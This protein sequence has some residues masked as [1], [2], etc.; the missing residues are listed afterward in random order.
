L[1]R[2]ELKPGEPIDK[3]L[4]R[5]KK[6]CDREG[7]TR[8]MRKNSYYEKPSERQKRREREREKE[9]SKSVRLAQ[10]KKLKARKARAKAMKAGRSPARREGGGHGSHGGYGGQGSRSR[11]SAPRS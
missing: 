3:A 5:F 2:L 7:L 4:R 6:I 1:I 8:D 9:R 11:P 10:K